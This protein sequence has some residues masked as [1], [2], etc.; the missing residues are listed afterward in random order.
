MNDLHIFEDEAE[1]VRLMFEKAKH[2][3]LEPLRIANYLNE[4]G[5]RTRRGKRWNQSTVARILSS[6]LYVGFLQKGGAKSPWLPELQ[7]PACRRFKQIEEK[8]CQKT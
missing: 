5:Y 4:Y 8:E 1:V 2:E 7:I 3:G 6:R